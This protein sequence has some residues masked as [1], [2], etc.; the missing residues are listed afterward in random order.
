[1]RWSCTYMQFK[2]RN[3][4]SLA[5]CVVGDAAHFPYRSSKYITEFF[6]DCDLPFVHDGSTRW[7]WATDRLT[8]LLSEP[9]PQ[10]TRFLPVSSMCSAYSWI[11][12]KLSTMTST[13]Q[14]H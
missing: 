11:G 9:S 12:R 2:S 7:A 1:M 5:E 6:E 3:V 8:E 10:P 4:R 14:R 13:D